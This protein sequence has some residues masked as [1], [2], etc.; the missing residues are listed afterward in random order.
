[1]LMATSAFTLHRGSVA[2]S[3]TS[4][5]P[6]AAKS[7]RILTKPTTHT[8]PPP[9]DR[10]VL[11]GGYLVNPAS[12]PAWL[13]WIRNLSPLSFAFEVMAANEMADQY[14]SIHVDGF[15][16]IGGI[17]GDG[18]W[19][20][21]WAVWVVLRCVVPFVGRSQ[22]AGWFV[23]LGWL[24]ELER[25]SAKAVDSKQWLSSRLFQ[26]SLQPTQSP[27]PSLSAHAR[28]RAVPHAPERRRP[29]RLLRWIRPAGLCLH[30]L[31]LVAARRRD[32]ARPPG[33]FGG[34]RGA[35]DAVQGPPRSSCG[36][37]VRWPF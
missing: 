21:V 30:L 26:T 8:S 1:M 32:L 25:K 28:P 20:L 37:A 33:R 4:S 31:H 12:I 9:L 3:K 11:V 2:S 17:K 5:M 23:E 14:F 35:A 34:P 18:E 19:R 15:P 29:R 6:D 24:V 16:E 36:G 27:P 13:R 7:L 22:Q 10:W